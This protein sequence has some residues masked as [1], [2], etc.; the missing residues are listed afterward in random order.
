MNLAGMLRTLRSAPLDAE[1]RQALLRAARGEGGPE[2]E[3][4]LETLIGGL[5]LMDETGAVAEARVEALLDDLG[6]E[7][8]RG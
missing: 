6:L 3:A 4:A 5:G 2:I 7:R 8:E 1:T